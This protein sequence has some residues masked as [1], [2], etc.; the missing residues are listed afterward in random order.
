MTLTL[1]VPVRNLLLGGM[2]TGFDG[3]KLRIYSGAKPASSN[4]APTGTLLAEITLP[5]DAFA[6]AAAGSIAKAGTWEDASANA[7]GNA[8]WARFSQVGDTDALDAAFHRI[9]C[10]VTATGGGGDLTID[11]VNIAA[12]QKVTVTGFSFTMPAGS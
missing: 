12:G 3:G 10:T 1:N 8:G 2:N 5:A 9:D 6:A 11:N 7:A 4:L